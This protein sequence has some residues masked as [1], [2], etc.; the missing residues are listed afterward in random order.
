MWKNT[1]EP[2]R[3]Q[4][5]IWCMRIACW[6]THAT[7][8]HSLSLTHSE[9]LTLNGLSTATMVIRT[10]LNVTSYVRLSCFLFRSWRWSPHAQATIDK[11]HLF[12]LE[13]RYAFVMRNG[14]P[15]EVKDVLHLPRSQPE[16]KDQ[17]PRL[18]TSAAVIF[19]T[20]YRS[21]VTICTITFN[22]TVRS[23]LPY[24]VLMCFTRFW[25]QKSLPLSPSSTYGGYCYPTLYET[26]ILNSVYPPP[27]VRGKITEIRKCRLKMTAKSF[28]PET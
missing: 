15:M 13:P 5:T 9:Y 24:R 6:V 25:E 14:C 12:Y 17:E 27:P 8:T 1:V 10:P 2:D 22:I 26:I 3:P 21:V 4:S 16:V 7:H 11:L 18:I 19:C 23:L 28:L 20:L